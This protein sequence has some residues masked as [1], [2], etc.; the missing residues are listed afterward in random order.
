MSVAGRIQNDAVIFVTPFDFALDKLGGIFDEPTYRSISQ[1]RVLRISTSPTH[2]A[3]RGVDVL[4]VVEQASYRNAVAIA[5]ADV[6]Q[7]RVDVALAEQEQ[8]IA[9]E[10][11]RLLQAREGIRP[12]PDTSLAARLALREPQAEAARAS[13]ARAEAQLA[14]AE[15]ALSRTV[16]RA[17]FNGR[18]RT[19]SVDVG[20]N[21]SAGQAVAELYDVD[22]AEMV[23]SLST[24][25]AALIDRL[26]E[27]RAGVDDWV[28][29]AR[30][31]SEFGGVWYEWE[32]YVDRAQG[33]L[34]PTTRT[35]DLVVR[36][37]RPFAGE[38]GPPLLMGS[39]ARVVAARN[40]DAYFALPRRA[41]RE[42]S[43]VWLVSE[44]ATVTSVPVQIIQEVEDT[45]FV[46]GDLA[47]GAQ[48]VTSDLSVMTEGMRV[49]VRGN[50]S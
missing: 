32:G 48:L 49:A 7:R 24:T 47:D 23:V 38:T 28:I 30:V 46:S 13:L 19:E 18:V 15:L 21:V 14:D 34:D 12:K 9:R 10:E 39:Y 40:L 20:Q 45:V 1:I 36:V 27:K 41:L 43:T 50:G 17:P 33:A 35:V 3:L 29:P 31:R 37:P 4:L 2:D 16:L 44:D 25:E 42:G 8:V 6:A 22:E 11:Y 26:W 5:R